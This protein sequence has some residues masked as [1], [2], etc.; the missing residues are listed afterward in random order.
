MSA[1]NKGLTSRVN[2]HVYESARQRVAKRHEYP[3]SLIPPAPARHQ[4][5]GIYTM[6]SRGEP[7]TV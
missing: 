4:R 3:P 5:C 6:L 2:A 7:D 1:G